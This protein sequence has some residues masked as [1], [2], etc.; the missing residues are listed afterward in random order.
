MISTLRTTD[1]VDG[2]LRAYDAA[3]AAAVPPLSQV[4]RGARVSPA[5][6]V[7][8]TEDTA[9]SAAPTASSTYPRVLLPF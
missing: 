8:L 6:E 9:E 2:D 4:T 3:G 7:S 1:R 5:S